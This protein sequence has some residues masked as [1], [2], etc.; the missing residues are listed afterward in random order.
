MN[1]SLFNSKHPTCSEKTLRV[2]ASTTFET[3]G[4]TCVLEHRRKFQDRCCFRS[5]STKLHHFYLRKMVLAISIC[6]TRNAPSP[7]D[8]I[9]GH[10]DYK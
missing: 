7:Q 1:G 4:K 2:E 6:Q 9:R 8:G 10:E 3:R 5:F